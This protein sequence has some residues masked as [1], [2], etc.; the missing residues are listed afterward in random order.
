MN[1]PFD[2]FTI[3]KQVQEAHAVRHGYP[4][5]RQFSDAELAPSKS[6][7]AEVEAELYGQSPLGELVGQLS[8][9]EQAILG[10]ITAKNLI[11]FRV[12]VS[13]PG[14]APEQIG[15]IAEHS[16]D[17][18]TKAMEIMFPDFDSEKPDGALSIKVETVRR[19]EAKSCAA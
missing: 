10:E 12:T 3:A 18:V 11:P 15:L 19:Q 6:L 16:C 2:F 8:P 4:V 17:A 7:I 5:N 13:I 14:R 9:E 1:K